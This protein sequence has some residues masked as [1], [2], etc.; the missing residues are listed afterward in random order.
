MSTAFRSIRTD[1]YPELRVV[2]DQIMN[3][4][5]FSK[6]ERALWAAF[7]TGRWVDLRSG[8]PYEDDPANADQWGKDRIVRA[9]VVTALLLGA[10]GPEPGKFPAVRLRGA[11]IT[12]RLDL[13][14][15]Q[16][17]SS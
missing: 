9:E 7:P 16:I 11:R 14:G 8:N 3:V 1:L 10:R 5:D 12:G 6:P 4:R 15:A 17:S 2:D 13:M